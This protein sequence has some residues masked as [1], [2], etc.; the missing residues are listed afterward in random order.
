MPAWGMRLVLLLTTVCSCAGWSPPQTRPPSRRVDT[1]RLSAGFFDGLAA[2]V[3]AMNQ[4]V[5]VQHVLVDDKDVALKLRRELEDRGV[6]PEAVGACAVEHS[7][8][9]SA[10]KTP[11]AQ[12]RQLRGRPGELVFKRGQMAKE[13][14]RA[15]FEGTIG[16]LQLV[17]TKF[18]FHLILV[19]GRSGEEPIPPPPPP[20]PASMPANALPQKKKT[21]K[22]KKNVGFG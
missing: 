1:S 4:E 18:G 11:D 3:A 14:E 8:C 12:M 2:N 6:S 22:K 19:N 13:F 9:G 15:A 5:T 17:E 20:P 7:T 21:K 10:K 16:S